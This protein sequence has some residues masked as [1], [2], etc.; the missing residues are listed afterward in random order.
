MA[1]KN[2]FFQRYRKSEIPFELAIAMG[3]VEGWDYIQKFGYNPL[4]TTG[5]DPEDIWEGGGIYPFS[6]NGVADIVSISS[7]DA[8]DTQPVLIFGLTADGT[9]VTQTVTLN[10]QTRVALTTPLWRV[11]RM[12]NFSY[13][14]VDFAGTVYCYSGT[15]NTGGVPSGGSVE[16]ARIT[17]GRNQTQMAVCTIPKGKVAFLY[18]AE[19]QF[20]YSGTIGAG[21]NQVRF[22]FN[23]RSYLNVFKTKKTVPL[24]TTGT[25]SHVD[26]RPF[27]DPLPALTDVKTTVAETTA[28]VNAASTCHFWIADEL[29]FPPAYLASIGQ[30]GYAFPI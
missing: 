22:E 25:T 30:P 1:F 28:D 19:V 12:E 26:V 29:N 24:L 2:L 3:Y 17:V 16:K 5:T 15:T 11:Y 9:D 23:A 27:P 21:T 13:P 18:R 6:A 7:S 20:G 4:I 8:G 14:G 10:G